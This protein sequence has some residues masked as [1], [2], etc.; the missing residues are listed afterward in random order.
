M[1]TDR[2]YPARPFIAASVA[3]FRDGRVLIAARAR[4][5]MELLYSL[6]GGLVKAGETLSEAA[7]RELHEEV[8]VEADLLGFVDHVEAIERDDTRRVRHH[9]VICAHAARWRAGEPRI[10]SEATDVR[11]VR[12]DEIAGFRTTPELAR[13]L[14]KA[15]AMVKAMPA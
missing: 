13:V 11:W 7:L 2:L 1:V 4:P 15:F 12:E 3:V 14:R 10:G 5:P 9:F 8:G 6:P